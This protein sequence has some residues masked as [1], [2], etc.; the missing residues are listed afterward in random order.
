VPLVVVAITLM[1]RRVRGLSR[2]AQDRFAETSALASEVLNAMPTVQAYT[3]EPIDRQRYAVA[4]ESAFASGIRRTRVRAGMTA[5]VFILVGASIV[6]VLWVGASDVLIGRMSASQLGQFVLYASHTG[7]LRGC[8]SGC[9]GSAA[10]PVRPNACGNTTRPRPR[11]PLS[12][13]RRLA[14]PVQGSW[15]F[16]ITFSYRHAQTT[17]RW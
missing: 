5:A 16:P 10:P 3:H 2:A 4:T 17:L 12:T 6:G 15:N 1:G 7:Q 9:R 13:P 11:S 8:T 14:Q